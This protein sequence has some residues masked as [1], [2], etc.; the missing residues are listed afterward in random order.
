MPLDPGHSWGSRRLSLNQSPFLKYADG[1]NVRYFLACILMLIGFVVPAWADQAD[2]LS[3]DEA[4]QLTVTRAGSGSLQLHWEIAD[5]YYLYREHM[6]ATDA[7][8]KAA[9]DLALPD[10]VRK[11]DPNF[12]A[13]EVYHGRVLAT[14][15]T[16]KDRVVVGYQGC[17]E[18]SICYPPISK[19]LDTR[20]LSI[21]SQSIGFSP[22]KFPSPEVTETGDFALAADTES[23]LVTSLLASGGPFWVV[24][25]FLVFGL[26]L[27]FT[28]CVLPMYPIL[29]ATLG[30]SGEKLSV[31]RGF[32]LSAT[33]VIAMALAFGFLGIAAALSGQNLQIV[34]QSP[35]AIGSVALIFVILAASMFGAF[36]LQLPS[37]WVNRIS[38][39]QVGDRGSVGSAAFMGFTS[40]LIVGPCVT[41][42]LAAA[43]LYIAQT[44]D[45]RLGAAALFALGL[46]QGLPL[47]VFGTIGSKALPRRGEWMVYFK[48]LFGFIF[49]GVATW[50][51]GRILPGNITLALWAV[52]CIASGVFLG[53]FDALAPD[54]NRRRRLGKAGGLALSI[55]GAILAVG[56]AAGA[57]DPLRPLEHMV[58]A[59]ATASSEEISF[60]TASSSADLHN[61]L[62]KAS[63]DHKPSLVYFT[64][65]WC[66][67]CTIIDREVLTASDVRQGLRDVERIKI[68]LTS[69]DDANQALMKDLAVIGPPTMIFFDPSGKE[70]KGSRLVGEISAS[71]LLTS[72]KSGER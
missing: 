4:F 42:P 3:A 49:L 46:G 2:L 17:K 29:A 65:D 22:S 44:G 58:G 33:Y 59:G 32:I 30:R 55:Y 38:G 6:L 20:T 47:V 25:S 7:D 53:G 14:M 56:A 27:A 70:A 28:P 5:G 18:N 1:I 31:K 72:A 41:A 66:V 39:T 52:I 16:S 11:D 54:S 19:I 13:T 35:Y 50:M 63:A 62:Q 37:S 64:A 45:A 71:A 9:I 23:G 57:S 48:Y 43:L 24:A 51:I 68:D 26:L 10:G 67:S 8:T 34:L 36:E 69:L 15:S 21:A 61:Q 40:A 60:N 12:G